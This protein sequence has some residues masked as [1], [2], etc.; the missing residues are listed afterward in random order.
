[1]KSNPTNLREVV[2]KQ[3]DRDESKSRKVFEKE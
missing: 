3:N 2:A 1:M